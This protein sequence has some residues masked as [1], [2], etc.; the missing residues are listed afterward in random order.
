MTGTPRI[1]LILYCALLS[2]VT[3]LVYFP[4]L[5]GGFIFDDY[6]SLSAL[7]VLE[8]DVSLERLKYYFS[9]SHSGPLMRPIPTLSFVLDAQTWPAEAYPFKRTN[10]IIHCLNSVLLFLLLFSVFKI[11][12]ENNAII[13]ITHYQR[14]L[15]YIVPDF[16]HVLQDGKIVKS[17]TKEL[18]ME[19]EEKGYDW[20]K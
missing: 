2:V 20:L 13:V 14:L 7:E 9:L 3:L 1:K 19:L 17:G 11:K 18:A 6:K 10:L 15:D 12:N 8:D 16:V 4:G 5:S